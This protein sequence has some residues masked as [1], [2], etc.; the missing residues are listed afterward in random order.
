MWQCRNNGV[1]QGEVCTEAL[2]WRSSARAGA[3]A[4]LAQHAPRATSRR[5]DRSAPPCTLP[6]HTQHP[7]RQLQA[8]IALPARV[9]ASP[10][11]STRSQQPCSTRTTKYVRWQL[12]QAA[13]KR[14]AKS[15]RRHP[16]PLPLPPLHT[17][18]CP[19]C[20]S[21]LMDQIFNLKFTS[22]QLVRAAKKCEK[23]E[24]DEKLKIKKAIEKGAWVLAAGVE[25]SWGAVGS[26]A[27]QHGVA[28][29]AALG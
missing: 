25:C 20:P 26:G 12:G 22:K 13:R 21:Q 3:L 23:E 4:L 19:L 15:R 16:L 17:P 29:T 27:A 9:P 5:P 8:W 2:D 24:K 10:G 11:S 18:L 7:E 14:Q 6:K 1:D 28:V